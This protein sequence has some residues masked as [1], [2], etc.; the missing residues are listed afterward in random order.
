MVT[1]RGYIM[2]HFAKFVTGMTRIDAIFS[3]SDF[4]GSAYLSQTGDTVVAVMANT[5]DKAQ[6]L[7]LDL[8]FYTQQGELYTTG[9]SNNFTKKVQTPATET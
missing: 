2:A 4:E 9:K 1:K 8:P 3:S 5:S 7:M 6:D